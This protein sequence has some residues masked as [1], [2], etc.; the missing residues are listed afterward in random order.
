LTLISQKS[1]IFDSARAPFVRFADI[2]PAGGEIRPQ[3]KPLLDK[4]EFEYF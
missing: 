4:L 1:K 3:G 2:F